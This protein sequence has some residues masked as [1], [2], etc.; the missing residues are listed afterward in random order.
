LARVAYGAGTLAWRAS[1]VEFATE[2]VPEAGD[3]FAKWWG[4]EGAQLSEGL[5]I[6]R[7]PLSNVRRSDAERYKRPVRHIFQWPVTVQ[8]VIGE[9]EKNTTHGMLIASEQSC[10]GFW[11]LEEDMRNTI[12]VAAFAA[13]LT[14]IAGTKMAAAA[15]QCL[16]E[17]KAYTEGVTVCNT[18]RPDLGIVPAQCQSDGIWHPV[19]SG[20]CSY[21]EMAG[22]KFATGVASPQGNYKCEENGTWGNR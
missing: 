9:N 10:P 13:A 11:L 6:G 12:V 17:G 22:S 3:G 7:G 15:A 1:G 2:I 5:A 16:Y 21:C 18:W 14:L 4:T 8:I 19:E 20:K